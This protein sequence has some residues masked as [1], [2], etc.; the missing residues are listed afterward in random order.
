MAWA[1]YSGKGGL[2][3]KAEIPATKLQEDLMAIVDNPK[4]GR[5]IHQALKDA[6]KPYVPRDTG[7]LYE[8]A[9]VYPKS[10]R[11]IQPYAHYQYQG[12]VYG[13]NFIGWLSPSTFGWR[14]RKGM[15]KHPTDR[16]LGTPGKGVFKPMFG[17]QYNKSPITWTFG[18]TT[19]GTHHHW[20]DEMMKHNK[21]GFHI[22]CTNVLKKRAK[23]LS[24]K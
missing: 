18:Y 9:K 4:T 21:R 24:K 7:K 13:P 19:P 11:F 16:E 2:R 12:V 6:L 17:Q 3:M 10:L 23:E 22:R 8:T 15:K 14:S 1:R 5:E 20:L